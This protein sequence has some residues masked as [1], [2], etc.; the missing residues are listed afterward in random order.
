MNG[1]FHHYTGVEV[2]RGEAGGDR[3]RWTKTEL[4]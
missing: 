1:A 2:L 3:R 4:R